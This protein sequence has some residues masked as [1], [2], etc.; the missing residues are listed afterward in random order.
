MLQLGVGPFSPHKGL[1]D[2]KRDASRR[3]EK[4]SAEAAQKD[5][6]TYS[7]FR[8]VPIITTNPERGDNV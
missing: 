2:K 6:Y 5:P 7:Y 1:Y 8:V 4:L 3:A